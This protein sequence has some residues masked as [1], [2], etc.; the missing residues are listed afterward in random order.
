MHDCRFSHFVK[1][2]LAYWYSF[3]IA[4]AIKKIRSKQKIETLGK[5][6]KNT[7]LTKTVP[8]DLEHDQFEEWVSILVDMSDREMDILVRLHDK[9]KAAAPN[10]QSRYTTTDSFWES[11]VS[12]TCNRYGILEEEFYTVLN[13]LLRTGFYRNDFKEAGAL[14]RLNPMGYTTLYF[15]K[16]LEKIVQG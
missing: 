15:E 10:F 2:A 1:K 7:Y 6:Y 11:F 3:L 12:E 14:D 5:L 4:D 9:E 13:R 8:S 16:F